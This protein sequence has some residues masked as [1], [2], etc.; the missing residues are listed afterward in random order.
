[1]NYTREPIIESVISPK[2]GCR[3]IIRNSNGVEQEDYFVDAIEIVSFGPALF[4]RSQER[5]KSFLVP[6]A[7]Y[8]VIEVKETRMVLKTA[9]LEKSIK[10]GSSGAKVQET[11][12]VSEK[13]ETP[14]IDKKRRRPRRKKIF[15]EKK[16]IKEEK[17]DSSDEKQEKSTSFFRRLFPPPSTLIKEKFQS[18]KNEDVLE[19][20]A[21][22]KELKET[23]EKEP[24][25]PVEK[26][27]PFVEKKKTKEGEA[28]STK[29]KDSSIEEKKEK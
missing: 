6:V 12:T 23:L 16:E 19:E 15:I 1:M 20:E 2:E 8:E 3:L 18:I 22:P 10:I 5:P 14:N 25:K 29:K 21:L 9:G 24:K 28:S 7:E 17:I 11:K 26:S 27:K 13:K 4:F